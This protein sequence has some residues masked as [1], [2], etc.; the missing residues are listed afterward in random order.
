MWALNMGHDNFYTNVVTAS[1]EGRTF[2]IEE[3]LCRK[4]FLTTLLT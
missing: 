3:R 4:P 1:L 2:E